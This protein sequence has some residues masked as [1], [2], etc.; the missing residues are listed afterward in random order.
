MN[1]HQ[2][3]K[4]QSRRM[5]EEALFLLMEKKPYAQI[6]VSGITKKAD[7]SRRTFYRLYHEKD[8]V[9]RCYF[10]RLCQKYLDQVSVL[11]S[12][13]I[14]RIA[15]EYFTFW[16]QY[17]DTLLLMHRRGLDEMLYFEL[18]RASRTVIKT[19]IGS[20]GDWKNDREMEYFADYSAG[21]FLLLLQR[22]IAEGMEGPPDQYA[23]AVSQALLKFISPV[24]I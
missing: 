19:R 13:D 23:Q 10:A 15:L 11:Y 14:S 24:R 9:L 5:I 18:G 12:Y 3:Q 6:T 4:E 2:K 17:R 22:W 7:I 16:R 8:E 1:G 20:G 21:G